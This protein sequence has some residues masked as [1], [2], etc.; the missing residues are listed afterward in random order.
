MNTP[1]YI[2]ENAE[3]SE[4]RA[5]AHDGTHPQSG[6]R[7]VASIAAE[8]WIENAIRQ[9]PELLHRPEPKGERIPQTVERL[10][11]VMARDA[12]TIEAQDREIARLKQTVNQLRQEKGEPQ[13][14]KL[15]RGSA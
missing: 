11:Q 1:I 4:T 12:E 10:Q 3:G 2:Y 9:H 7:L 15:R 14:K 8:A 13:W 6:W 5:V